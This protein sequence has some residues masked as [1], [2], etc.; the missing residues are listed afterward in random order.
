MCYTSRVVVK[1]QVQLVGHDGFKHGLVL[2]QSVNCINLIPVGWTTIGR[3]HPLL[4]SSD[5]WNRHS[6]NILTPGI[7]PGY[8]GASYKGVYM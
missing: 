5:I 1:R 6:H 2:N 4:S 3:C 7:S 8:N